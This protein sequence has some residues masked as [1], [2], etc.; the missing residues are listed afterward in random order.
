[1]LSLHSF[2]LSLTLFIS[3]TAGLPNNEADRLK[4]RSLNERTA[5]AG[6]YYTRGPRRNWT[7]SPSLSLAAVAL[8]ERASDNEREREVER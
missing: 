4:Y 5:A 8:K 7:L 2:S 6:G 1:M 3:V